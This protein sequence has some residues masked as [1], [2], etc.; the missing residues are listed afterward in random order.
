MSTVPAKNMWTCV[1]M[2][3]TVWQVLGS[4]THLNPPTSS[5][6]LWFSIQKTWQ[7][8]CVKKDVFETKRQKKVSV[9]RSVGLEL[10]SSPVVRVSRVISAFIPFR[11][12]LLAFTIPS[13]T[14]NC[15]RLCFLVI[16]APPQFLYLRGVSALCL[17]FPFPTI[18]YSLLN[19]H[20]FATHFDNTCS[21]TH[22]P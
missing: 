2:G 13:M 15:L 16:A 20:G 21:F 10:K 5:Q 9:R 22:M 12:V 8:K 3:D 14:L 1:W 7:P 18:F 4:S 17:P 6:T 11:D 19:A